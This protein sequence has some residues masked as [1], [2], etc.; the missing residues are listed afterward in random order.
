MRLLRRFMRLLLELEKDADEG[1]RL[2]KQSLDRIFDEVFTMR[3]CAPGK[4]CAQV[5]F[6]SIRY[7][8]AFIGYAI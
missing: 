8:R 5:G 1:G 6:T 4:G 7:H 3:G 2:S